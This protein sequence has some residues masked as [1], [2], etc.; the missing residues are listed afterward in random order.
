MVDT[1]N[2]LV[3]F[4]IPC[5]N[6]ELYVE[7]CIK[8]IQLQKHHNIEIIPVEDGSKDNTGTILD[9]LA[10]EDS[11]IRPIHKQNEGVSAARNTGIDA[12]KGDYIVFVDGDDYIAEN[13]TDYMLGL[14]AGNDADFALSTNCY[15]RKGEEQIIQDNIRMVNNEDAVALLLGPRVIVGCWN[16][17]YKL[18]FLRD[19]SL[20]FSTE[21]FYGEGLYFINQ[22]AQYANKVVVGEKKVY[23][24]RRNNYSSACTTIKIQNFYNGSASIDAIE[25]D[26]TIKSPKVMGI[27]NWHRC[28]F[29]MGTVVRIK[30]AGVVAENKDYYKECLSYV[31]SHFM[32][33]LSVSGVGL[34]KKGLLIGTAISPSLMVMLDKWR[35]K[36][37]QGESV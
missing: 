8:S 1:N 33:C 34:Y 24:Y 6:V 30:T 36:K 17:I 19:K 15:T 4:V 14:V 22:V 32:S 37:I 12:A 11:R 28:Q 9:K 16:K 31:R 29:K 5:Y 23:Y 27:L 25:R 10:L 26:L 13:F 3:S 2:Y 7:Q 21:M 20:K 18:Q 35:R